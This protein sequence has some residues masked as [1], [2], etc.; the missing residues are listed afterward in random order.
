MVY[1]KLAVK[2]KTYGQVVK[3]NDHACIIKQKNG[4]GMILVDNGSEVWG[5]IK[6]I[7]TL[8]NENIDQYSNL[9]TRSN[10]N[11][12][13]TDSVAEVFEDLGY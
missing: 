3:E 9:K 5:M 10:N 12:V 8:R 7:E 4:R 1:K 2:A 6:D 11:Y 13:D